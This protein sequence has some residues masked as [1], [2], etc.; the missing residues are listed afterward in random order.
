MENLAARYPIIIQTTLWDGEKSMKH[1]EI[2]DQMGLVEKIGFCTGANSWRT[3][4]IER[5]G[6][7]SFLMTDG[8]HGLRKLMNSED[9]LGQEAT[10]QATSFPTASL[11]ACSWDRDLLREMGVALAEEALQEDVSLILGPGANIQR[12]PLCGR[13]FEYFSEDPTLAGEM[14]VAWIE[15]VQSLG[16]GASLKHFA[17]NSQENLRML[18]DSLIAERALREIYLPAFERAVKTARPATVM[19]AYNKLNG[20]YCSDH[21]YL[22][23]TILR[24]EWGFDGVIVTDWGAMNDRVRAFEAGLDLEMPGSNGLHDAYILAAV[25]NGV[26][27][28]ERI[29]ECVDRLIDLARQT[30]ANRKPGFHYDSEAHHQLARKIAAQSAVLMKNEDAILPVRPGQKIAL[31]GEMAKVPRYQGTG[32]SMVTPTRVS[33]A[34]DG[35]DELGLAYTYYP[36][37]SRQ[38]PANPVLMEEAAAGAQQA[39]LAVIFAGLTEEFDAEGFARARMAMP[40]SHNALIHRVA[41]AQPNT[42]VVLAGGAPVEMPWIGEV[43]AVLNMLLAGQ[44]GGLAA[45]DLLSGRVNPSGK[46]SDTY[47]FR[48]ADVPS[49]GFFETGG[50]QAQ[51]RESI[52]VGYRYYDK[53]EKEVLFP[54]GHGLSYTSFEYRDLILS[55]VE[56]SAADE[57]KVSAI[58]KNSGS[59]PGAEIVQLYVGDLTPGIFRPVRELRDFTKVFLQTGEE[60]TIAFTMDSRAF[61]CY[62]PAQK[63][64][65]VPEGRYEVALGAS[66]R[67]IRLLGEVGVRGSPR[68]P[69]DPSLPAWY[70]QPQGQ[71]SAADFE[72]VLG[73]SIEPVIRSEEHTSEL[74]HQKIS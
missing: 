19:C 53:A 8:P 57:L 72:K 29:D 66:S 65:V 54:F 45:A 32:S 63:A 39:D 24:E 35:F 61:S 36:G 64:W 58:I 4:S 2:L 15:G 50:R 20:T 23:R 74:H 70:L 34:V 11:T 73:R 12:N 21:T 18:S 27:A 47:P 10:H 7:P 71:V 14:T 6:I 40:E 3:K 31:I 52:Y 55:Q 1:K 48:Y 68:Q 38:G 13:N 25:K 16:V 41:A 46:L 67:D 5:F 30:A 43:K 42:V 9:V 22:L 37:Y 56:M 59:R 33:S 51:Y 44:T 17:G 62:D 49:A 28:E 60:Q 26:L 69:A